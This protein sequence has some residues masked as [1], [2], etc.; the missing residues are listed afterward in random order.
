MPPIPF[1]EY[2]FQYYALNYA[3]IFRQYFYNPILIIFLHLWYNTRDS[4]LT[5][6]PAKKFCNYSLFLN[7]NHHFTCDTMQVTIKLDPRFEYVRYSRYRTGFLLFISPALLRPAPSPAEQWSCKCILSHRK[8]KS[9]NPAKRALTFTAISLVTD[10]PARRNSVQMPLRLTSHYRGAD[11]G[12]PLILDVMRRVA[13]RAARYAL[14]WLL[15]T[16]MKQFKRIWYFAKT[17]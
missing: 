4:C 14:H 17:Q 1:I 6:S 10:Y 7:V 3:W 11:T 8:K 12:T 16:D 13:S 15:G 9:T 5:S 2:P